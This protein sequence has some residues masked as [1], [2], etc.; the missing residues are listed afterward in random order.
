L[1]LFDWI[2]DICGNFVN[3]DMKYRRLNESELK[4]LEQ[5]FIRFLAS[6]Q[7]TASD[8]EKL[9]G[10]ETEKVNGLIELFSDQVFDKVFDKL[11]Y[12]E[13]KTLNDI[14]T[15]HC[16]QDK[17]VMMGLFVEGNAQIDFSKNQGSNDIMEAVKA[18]GAAVK[19]YTAEKTYKGD[20]NQELFKMMENGCL[21]SKDGALY[22]TLFSLKGQ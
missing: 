6:N 17:I 11:E 16:Q 8:W 9:K 3:E 15:F 4:D 2:A 1:L 21:I 13:F 5:D 19:I 18:S 22:K 10:E 12:L 7:I 20:R 14:K